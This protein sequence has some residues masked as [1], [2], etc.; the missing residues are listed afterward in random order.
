MID[1]VQSTENYSTKNLKLHF[2]YD[3]SVAE[4]TG[5]LYDDNGKT[6]DAFGKGQY[7]LLHFKNQSKSKQIVISFASEK[8]NAYISATRNVSLLV[9]NI[10]AKPKK[11]TINGKAAKFNWNKNSNVLEIS[12]IWE[13]QA[14]KN[15]NIQLGN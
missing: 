12:V 5:K 4:S 9:H 8:G 1:V 2:Y 11:I 3:N 13:K 10:P 15:I 6:P 7:E 14:A